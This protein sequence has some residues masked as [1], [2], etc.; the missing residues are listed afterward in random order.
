VY[1]PALSHSASM[2]IMLRASD[3]QFDP[4]L[5]PVLERCAPRWETIFRDLTD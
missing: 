4:A 1:K 3:G 5:L 2:E